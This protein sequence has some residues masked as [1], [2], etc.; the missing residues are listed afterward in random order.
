LITACIILFEP[1]HK[2]YTFD[3]D[4]E[5]PQKFH[6]VAVPRIGGISIYFGMGI[7]AINHPEIK[8]N[9]SLM[10]LIS[11]FP[12]FLIGLIED[13]TKRISIRLRIIFISLSAILGIILLDVRII[14]V[15]M[16]F[17][18]FL[19][20][21]PIISIG[22]T[23]F[24]LVG[25]VNAYNIIDGFNGLSSL[26]AIIALS[27]LFY[28]YQV[29][30]DL[31][32]SNLCLIIIGSILG[33]FCFNYPKGLIFLGDGGAYLIGFCIATLS[34]LLISRHQNIS[35]WFVL[36]IN[37]YPIIETIFSI[38]R[39]KIH[40]NKNPGHPD[41]LHLHTLIFRRILKNKTKSNLKLSSNSLTAPR[42][43]IFSI[44]ANIIACK[45]YYST[46]VCVIAF[47]SFLLLYVYYYM[48]I[49]KFRSF[50]SLIK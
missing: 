7:I 41:G 23:I 11:S 16:I 20:S 45:Y 24:S 49:I 34:I 44:I 12:A 22:F 21:I 33:F 32:F 5:S 25:L 14:N 10:L 40:Q 39:R 26:V 4:L 13:F 28:L 8:N 3:L 6:K 48:M 50:R 37:A 27:S 17:I 36:L 35:P 19:F 38:Y 30:D 42:I 1:W 47:F 18:N 2:K 46:I 31:V 43:W 29:N 9:I 15:D